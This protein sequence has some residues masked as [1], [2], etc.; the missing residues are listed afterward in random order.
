MNVSIEKKIGVAFA[1]ACAL[2]ILGMIGVMSY[3]RVVRLREDIAEH[4][5][6]T[7]GSLSLLKSR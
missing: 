6:R 2:A 5:R 1:F 3:R 4:D 7:D